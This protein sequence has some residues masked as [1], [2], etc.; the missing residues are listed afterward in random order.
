MFNAVILSI[1]KWD[2]VEMKGILF[3]IG[4]PHT[5]SVTPSK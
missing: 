4:H 3:S 1:Q 5:M 2:G